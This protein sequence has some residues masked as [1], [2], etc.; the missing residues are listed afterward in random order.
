MRTRTKKIIAG[1]LAAL[2]IIPMIVGILTSSAY[3][4]DLS[5]KDENGKEVKVTDF[6]DTQGHWAQPVCKLWAEHGVING[7]GDAKFAPDQ[8]IKRCDLA[9]IIDRMFG[10]DLYAYNSFL[11]LEMGTY[12][13]E[14]M[15]KC[16]AYNYIQGDGYYIMPGDVATRE[17]VAT[18]L[19]R[20]FE[21]Q[22]KDIRYRSTG[23]NDMG[24]VSSWASEAVSTMAALGYIKGY[25]GYFRPQDYITRAE[26]VTMVNN[27]AGNFL[28]GLTN[29]G[30]GD[31]FSN[32]WDTNL[33]SS[34]KN[35]SLL[36]STVEG[37]VYSL[38]GTT[39]L[40]LDNTE[41][42]GT[43]YIFGD[44][45]TLTL[46]NTHIDKVE[47]FGQVTI[48]GAGNIDEIYIHDNASGT[49][50]DE[51]IEDIILAPHCLVSIEKGYYENSSSRTKHY[52]GD[53]ILQDIASEGTIL[54]S[55]PNVTASKISID[56]NNRV[57]VTQLKPGQNGSGILKTFGI[58]VIDGVETPSI[59]NYDDKY[60][61][62]ESYLDKA[63]E[64]DITS[65]R[66][67]LTKEICTQSKNTVCTYIPY[68]MNTN[69]LVAYGTPVTLKSYDWTY[70]VKLIDTGSY[71]EKVRFDCWI[72]GDS[73]PKI[74]SV[75]CYYSTSLDYTETRTYKSMSLDT[76]L[77]TTTGDNLK[78]RY[79]A[80]I[81][82]MQDNIT[83]LY[84]A[85][86]HF[87]VQIN[88]ADGTELYNYPIL[89]NA[90]P[91]ELSPVTDIT[92]GNLVMKDDKSFSI[93]NNVL[94]AYHE[95]VKDYGIIYSLN[96]SLN[97]DR[98][99]RARAG[100]YAES[101]STKSFDGVIPR[102]DSD[103]YVLYYR[104]YVRTDLGYYYGDVKAFDSTDLGDVGGPV[105]ERKGVRYEGVTSTDGMLAIQASE[106]EA[107]SILDFKTIGGESDLNYENKT[108][109]NNSTDCY[110]RTDG[111]SWDT[112]GGRPSD[113]YIPLRNLKENETY[114][115]R[116]RLIKGSLTSAVQEITFNTG[117]FV[118]I[119]VTDV[120]K[121]VGS[122]VFYVG[123][124]T[125][126]KRIEVAGISNLTNQSNVVINGNSFVTQ[127]SD[128]EETQFA[129][130]LKYVL[131]DGNVM[132]N[133]SFEYTKYIIVR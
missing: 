50:L 67:T 76:N 40:T 117:S 111:Y 94:R 125:V 104:A 22:E 20:A 5:Y 131:S 114:V 66:G 29:R 119:G 33:T 24:E 53:D 4:L 55:S 128:S 35:V 18:I 43:L 100:S 129:F 102:P 68:A 13:T 123:D 38:H 84:T 120:N 82:G 28:S 69:G 108:F 34:L 112:I 61:F 106:T 49:I 126:A 30:L 71:P 116:F 19:Y 31:K 58:L 48:K 41:I 98:W 74:S 105:L 2:M 60:S 87:G 15:L 54:K 80:D 16:N 72:T 121:A 113:V 7:I 47:A 130:A 25:N 103:N 52:N 10:L 70:D 73:I 110:I 42:D 46:N 37:D 78:Y 95:E 57:T 127:Y 8:Y 14:S 45:V 92:T 109:S 23:F 63:Y 101:N 83:K 39:S 91:S 88:F 6:V 77:S 11:D 97:T 132:G 44:M 17:Q 51:T 86:R 85:P 1:V 12:Y 99:E 21:M 64:G 56:A 90:E 89:T 93:K 81:A 122:G 115:L 96:S 59:E 32:R 65:Q 36:R 62:R 107:V 9:C 133:K 124:C 79:I 75:I 26:F 118:S 27:I 3:A